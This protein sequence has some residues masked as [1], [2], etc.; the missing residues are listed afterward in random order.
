MAKHV[1][2]YKIPIYYDCECQ[3][4]FVILQKKYNKAIKALRLLYR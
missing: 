3:I 4:N 1:W 2:E